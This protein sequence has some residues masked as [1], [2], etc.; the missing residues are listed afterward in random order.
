MKSGRFRWLVILAWSV[1]PW[2]FSPCEVKPVDSEPEA[3]VGYPARPHLKT[4]IIKKHLFI[5]T[6]ISYKSHDKLI[7]ECGN[8]CIFDI[9]ETGL[10]NSWFGFKDDEQ[11]RLSGLKNPEV[12]DNIFLWCNTILFDGWVS[13]FNLRKS[14]WNRFCYLIHGIDKESRGWVRQCGEL[15]VLGGCSGVGRNG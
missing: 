12:T 4:T 7:G 8:L 14:L 2:S 1:Q 3:S 6:F 5:S 15:S 10:G 13:S 11:K 9:C